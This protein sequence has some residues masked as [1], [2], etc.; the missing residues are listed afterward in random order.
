MSA[1]P[2]QI[3]ID[4]N[5]SSIVYSPNW[6]LES[7]GEKDSAGNFGP[8]L[9]STLHGTSS[10]GTFRY[11]FSGTQISVFG[12][13]N[14][15]NSSS[16][17]VDPS[18]ECL[19]DNN[20]IGSTPPFLFIE[21]N[22]NLCSADNLPSGTHTLTVN[23]F[24]HGR[25]FWFDYLQYTP[26]N[27]DDLN[28]ALV[29]VP[30]TDPDIVYD[31]T[32]QNLGNIATMTRASGSS[33]TLSFTGIGVTWYG[34]VPSELPGASSRCSYSIDGDAPQHFFLP[35][36]QP[37]QPTQFNQIFFQTPTLSFGPH[38]MTV[39]FNG[40][41]S[42]TP[43]GLLSLTVQNSS[44]D[45]SPSIT[46]ASSP[47]GP[48]GSA[49]INT[50]SVK[51][52]STNVPAIVCGVLA[53]I[54]ILCLT[55]FVYLKYVRRRKRTTR[56]EDIIKPFSISRP[57]PRVVESASLSTL[58]LFG[59]PDDTPSQPRP[60]GYSAPTKPRRRSIRQ[61]DQYPLPSVPQLQPAPQPLKPTHRKSDNREQPQA[62]GSRPARKSKKNQ[63]QLSVAVK[64]LDENA[65][66]Y[67][68]YQTWGQTKALEAASGA[69]AR[70]SYI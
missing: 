38:N 4:D 26:S 63:P 19:I 55:A 68:G 47:T 6:T 70:D 27:V 46:S 43:L 24:S 31:G 34:I 52:K 36:L 51:V 1:E 65:S 37:N 10:N 48:T 9:R 5:D 69:R 16:G 57:P 60:L 62:S 67:G 22:W 20:S 42:S 23:T 11:Q 21:N 49:I 12:T 53:A 3:I 2:R 13:T 25:H 29:K 39:V 41:Q 30:R 54:S 61:S 59:S 17:I 35:S 50:L 44:Q 8:T 56:W 15:K 18:W 7:D 66:Y 32:W 28:N 58:G 64:D 40:D 14:V 45:S 33:A